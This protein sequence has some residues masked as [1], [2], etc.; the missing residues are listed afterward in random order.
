MWKLLDDFIIESGGKSEILVDI[1]TLYLHF[2]VRLK[3]RMWFKPL[4]C[5][6]HVIIL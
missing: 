4:T 5:V 1:S 6:S 2:S 3:F